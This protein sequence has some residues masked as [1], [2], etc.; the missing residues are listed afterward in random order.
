MHAGR[1]RLLRRLEPHGP[2]GESRPEEHSRKDWTN[3]FYG[4]YAVGNLKINAEYR[5]YYRDVIAWNNLMEVWADNRSWYTSASYRL[6]RRFEIGSYYSDLSTVYKRGTLPASLNTSLPSNHIHDKV[7]SGRVDVSKF[8]DIK[9]EGHFEGHFM[10][11]FNNNQY[12]AG[13]Y[14][15]DNPQGFQPKTNLLIVRTGWYF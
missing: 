10:D 9:V 6:S 8:W 2:T 7:I 4:E 14:I 1:A 15:P 5:R 12:P 11:G 3:Q 13:F